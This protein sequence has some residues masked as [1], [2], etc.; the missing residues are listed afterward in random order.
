MQIQAG[1]ASASTPSEDAPELSISGMTTEDLIA[2]C[3]FCIRRAMTFLAQG[4]VTI[5]DMECCM[6]IL[7][8]AK[9]CIYGKE[10]PILAVKM[11]EDSGEDLE[12]GRIAGAPGAN[13]KTIKTLEELYGFTKK[14][15]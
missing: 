7:Q 4:N 5:R 8:S 13:P 12:P 1:R 6:R 11:A 2:S 14:L 15:H 3:G 10:V 9:E